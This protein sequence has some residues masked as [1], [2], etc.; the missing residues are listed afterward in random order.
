MVVKGIF[1]LAVSNENTD[2]FANQWRMEPVPVVMG[3]REV[4]VGWTIG[5]DNGIAIGNELL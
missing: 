3:G 2:Y 4:V 1:P 5:Y